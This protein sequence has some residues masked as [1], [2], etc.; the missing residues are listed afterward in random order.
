[1][2]LS[3]ARFLSLASTTNH[4]ASAMLVRDSRRHSMSR[5]LAVVKIR[6]RSVSLVVVAS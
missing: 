3:L 6:T 1:M 2:Q 4:G 5:V